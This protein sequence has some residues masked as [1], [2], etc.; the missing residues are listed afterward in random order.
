MPQALPC[1]GC[2]AAACD[3]PWLQYPI[4]VLCNEPMQN[5]LTFVPCARWY[6][7]QW[8]DM[9]VVHAGA[10]WVGAGPGLHI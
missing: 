7:H 4:L 10:S 5:A 2:S 9:Q 1:V 8:W 6:V 3:I